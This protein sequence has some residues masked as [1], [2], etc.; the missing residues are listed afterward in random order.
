MEASIK[1]MY[2]SPVF[3][4]RT[5]N[6]GRLPRLSII[7]PSFNQATFLERTLLSVLNQGYPNLEYILMDGAS[8]DGSVDVIRRYAG[9]LGYWATEQD[10]G[11]A[12]AVNKGLARATGEWVGF[13]N[14]DDIYLPGALH[15]IG[16]AIAKNPEAI[17]VTGHIVHMDESDRLVDVQLVDPAPTLA[18]QLAVGIQYHNQATFWKRSALEP[19]GGLRE[20]LRFCL[21]FEFFTRQLARGIRPHIIQRY[22][23]GFRGHA[24]AKSSTLLDVARREHEEI[25]SQYA[26]KPMGST[27]LRKLL[28]RIRK[29][30]RF[31]MA[32]QG[33][34]VLRGARSERVRGANA[35]I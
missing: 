15:A 5:E 30:A 6:V 11:Q 26:D 23:G 7:T 25:V 22:I 9:R 28:S 16:G 19:L 35:G 12:H 10:R 2:R 17:V 14:S 33:W 4:R 1:A 32:G 21:D 34:Y 20:D 27:Q 3:A 13:Q 18:A 8:Q 29:A 31:M 24:A